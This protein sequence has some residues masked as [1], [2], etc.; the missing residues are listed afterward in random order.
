MSV[1]HP[2]AP[3]SRVG[4][5]NACG[6]ARVGFQEPPEPCTTLKGTWTLGVLTDPRQE[7]GVAKVELA[8]NHILSITGS[9]AT[10]RTEAPQPL[11]WRGDPRRPRASPAGTRHRRPSPPPQRGL[12]QERWRI[13]AA[14]AEMAHEGRRGAV[15]PRGPLGHAPPEGGGERIREGR[16]RR[17][18]PPARGGAGVARWGSAVPACFLILPPVLRPSLGTVSL[19]PHAMSSSPAQTP[20]C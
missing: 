9:G 20:R 13:Q 6:V 18:G 12:H 15:V 14:L 10:P 19:S 8:Q 1:L 5:K 11:T 2:L 4:L 3:I 17:G 7:G 16:H